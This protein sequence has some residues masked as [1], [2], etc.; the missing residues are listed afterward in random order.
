MTN[1]YEFPSKEDVELI[2]GDEKQPN[3]F[4]R[5]KIKRWGNEVNFSIGII[6]TFLGSHNK[7]GDIVE[8]N[9]GHGVG[10]KLYQKPGDQFEFEISLDEKP[11]TGYVLLSIEAKGLNFFY[12]PPLTQEEI[13]KGNIRPDNV[14]GSYA[15]YHKVMK[16]NYIGGNNYRAGKFCHIYR[17]HVTDAKGKREWCKMDITGALMKI[18]IPD[19]LVYPV[20]I[21]PTFGYTNI[22]GTLFVMGSDHLKG[23]I[24]TSPSD[25]DTA[26]SISI[27]A[28]RYA[29]KH[30]YLKGVIV[31]NSNLNIITNGVG[32]PSSLVSGDDWY[33]SDFATD[34][35]PAPSTEY[36]L[37]AIS[38]DSCHLA[39]DTGA[40]NQG[41]NDLT[42]SYDSPTDPTD[43]TS[44][45]REYSI[46]CTYTAAA[47]G[48]SIP[49][50]MHHLRQQG[51]S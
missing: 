7:V 4:P 32:S 35:S 2:V 3:F 16:G 12:Q 50:I 20:V 27:Y 43:A 38:S 39:Y 42:N 41:Y 46:Y 22:G 34:P 5:M 36:V 37:M 11:L 47:G 19:G 31:L 15:V 44:D 14:V 45:D 24:F 6:S 29:V 40:T 30:A 8:W 48:V 28:T 18:T 51:I 49:I 1:T 25:I 23:S 13:D 26:Q 17:P 21:D 9:D 10:T 33:V